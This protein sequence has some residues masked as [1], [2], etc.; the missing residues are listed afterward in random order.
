M[1][2]YTCDSGI[3]QHLYILELSAEQNEHP[4]NL[5][6]QSVPSHIDIC[7]LLVGLRYHGIPPTLQMPKRHPYNPFLPAVQQPLHRH[8]H[9]AFPAYLLLQSASAEQHLYSPPTPEVSQLLRHI[10]LHQPGQSQSYMRSS[11]PFPLAWLA[12]WAESSSPN[13]SQ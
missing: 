12:Q 2:P 6:A 4:S 8:L 13:Q 9:S 3:Q 7:F 5:L 11:V 1:A 10:A